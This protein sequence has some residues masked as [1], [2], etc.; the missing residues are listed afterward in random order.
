MKIY[1]KKKKIDIPVK[2]VSSIGK[3]FG[4]MFRNRNTENL[5]FNFKAKTKMSIHSLFVFFPFIALWLDDKNKVIESRIVNPFAFAIRGKK[6]FSKLIELPINDKN[7]KMIGFFIGK[8]F[9]RFSPRRQ[10]E[11]RTPQRR[12]SEERFK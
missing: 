5:L 8:S 6:P 3:V 12:H 9:A 2:N 11:K 4:L 10:K 1:F 7:R